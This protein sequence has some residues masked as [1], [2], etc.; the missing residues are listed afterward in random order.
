MN[1]NTCVDLLCQNV[2]P[3]A[4]CN[5]SKQCRLRC[6]GHIINLVIKA[7]FFGTNDDAFE[8]K[9]EIAHFQQDEQAELELWHRKGPIGKLH[10]IVTY[11]KQTL[12]RS[13][14]FSGLQ[15]D[16]SLELDGLYVIA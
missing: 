6:I 11:I 13:E 5:I 1:N 16:G 2:F 9:A 3:K 10:N 4:A 14:A 8:L 7:L 15:L 12:Q